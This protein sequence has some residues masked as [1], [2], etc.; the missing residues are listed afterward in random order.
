MIMELYFE[1]K[2]CETEAGKSISFVKVTRKTIDQ[3]LNDMKGFQKAKFDQD[4]LIKIFHGSSSL[5]QAKITL[6]NTYKM[7][8][9]Q[10]DFIMGTSLSEIWAF[11]NKRE[12]DYKIKQLKA[13]RELLDE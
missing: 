2:Y 11:C 3:R 13:L 12:I 6:R 8:A 5:V 9:R 1:P 10:A 7:T 4:A